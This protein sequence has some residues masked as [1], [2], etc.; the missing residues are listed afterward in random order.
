MSKEARK[1]RAGQASAAAPFRERLPFDLRALEVFLAVCETGTM[2]S[3]ARQMEMTQPAVS[4][5][6]ADLERRSGVVLFDRAVRPLGLT[7]SGWLLRQ[8]ASALLADAAQIAPMLNESRKGRL[9]LIRLGLVDSLSRALTTELAEFLAARADQVSILLGLTSLHA[10]ELI[11]RRLDMFLGVDELVDIE[12]LERWPL[13]QEPYVILW[14]ERLAGEFKRPDLA[15][16]SGRA[17]L[18]RYSARSKTGA[19]IDRH[20]RRLRLDIPRKLEFDTP[21]GVTAAVAA[22]LGWAITT[23]LCVLEADVPMNDLKIAALPGPSLS[24]GLTLVARGREMGLLPKQLASHAG[25][26]LR[27]KIRP[28]IQRHCPSLAGEFAR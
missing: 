14:P 10:S 18:I 21:Y 12:G 2:A 9:P 1:F 20:L 25:D 6:V 26:A 16:L 17:P 11:S 5:I 15:A 13:F 4:Q 8:R 22:G 23:P 3:A 27:K 7:P 24:R 19:E 28:F